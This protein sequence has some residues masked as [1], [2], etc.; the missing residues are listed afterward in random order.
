MI[1]RRVREKDGR[2]SMSQKI[3][4]KK[5]SYH[6]NHRFESNHKYFTIS[7]YTIA[8]VSICAV[9]LYLIIN[10]AQTKE[11]IGDFIRNIMPFLIALFIAFILNPMVRNIDNFLMKKFK[12][13]RKMVRAFFSILLTYASVVFGITVMLLYITPQLIRSIADLLLILPDTDQIYAFITELD[14]NYATELWAPIDVFLEKQIPELLAYG[15]TFVTNLIP[16]LYQFSMSLVK[17]LI[18]ILL[19]F[20][21]SCYMILDKK[22]L[23][24]NGKRFLYAILSKE[25]AKGLLETGKECN[26]IFSKYI[27]GKSIDSLLIGILCFILM[28]L[29]RLPYSILLSVIVGITNMIPYFGPFIGAIPGLFILIFVNPIQSLIFGIMILVLQQ[30]DGLYLG[31]KILGESTGLKPLWIIF[32]ITVGGAYGGMLGMFFGVPIM[33]VIAYLLNKGVTK[34]LNNRKVIITMDEETEL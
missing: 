22:T 25:A 6:K 3:E 20:V 13:K 8:V 24:Y 18:N 28:N 1:V 16:K 32:A 14:L 7:I 23:H 10:F 15:T 33:A 4:E 17:L 34:R 9:I 31:P 12:I 29:L 19:S 11:V 27:I 5:N 26:L 21:I 2:D 30:F